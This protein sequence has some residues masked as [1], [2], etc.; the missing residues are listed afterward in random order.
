MIDLPEPIAVVC[1]DAGAANHVIA[2]LQA[3]QRRCRVHVGGP[4]AAAWERV[5]GSQGRVES[6][7]AALDGAGSLL[8][9]SGWASDLE[10]A[11]RAAARERGLRSVAVVDHWVNYEMRFERGGRTVL[12]DEVWVT[13]SFAAERAR[14]CF[15][16]LVVR[17]R[18]NLYLQAQLA[19]VAPVAD[20]GDD[21]LVVLEPMRADWGRGVAGEFQALDYL[22]AHLDALNLAPG[23]ALRLRPHPSDPG[24][25]YTRWI[26]AHA[27]LGARLD[28]APTLAAALSRCKIVAGCETYALVVALAAGRRVVC[29]L[30]PWAPPSRLPQPGIVHLREI[31]AAA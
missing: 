28:D 1:H 13:D 27:A 31:A 2:W 5:F 6:I 16:G 30:P 22:A 23:A 14:R 17:E 9:G 12:P 18:P 10:H 24:G 20:A 4:A 25:K 19:G 21:L 15:P 7:D 11:A 3:A 8:S 26:D 29:M